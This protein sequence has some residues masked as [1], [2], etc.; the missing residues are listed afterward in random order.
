VQ[1]SETAPE[2]TT[3]AVEE[4]L[5]L[6]GSG[7]VLDTL[8]VSEIT[9]FEAVPEITSYV[10]RKTAVSPR[11]RL[12]IVQTTSPELA[13]GAGLAQLVPTGATVGAN[14]KKVVFAGTLS[15]IVTGDASGPKLVTCTV[16]TAWD[17]AATLLEMVPAE[18]EMSELGLP[19][20]T[21][22]KELSAYTAP[23]KG[24]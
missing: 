9:V 21:T 20:S 16:K 18:I 13:P 15:V 7:V 5:A 3:L 17:P 10:A 8:A 24:S 22:V 2:T 4:L 23:P 12:G 11:A 14:S 6:L 1:V 19:E